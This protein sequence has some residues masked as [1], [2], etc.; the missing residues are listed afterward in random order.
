MNPAFRGIGIFGPAYRMMLENDSHAPSSVD[1]VL[2]REMVKLCSETVDF[3]YSTHTP[4]DVQ[5]EKGSRPKLD[6]YVEDIGKA[7]SEEGII[8]NIAQF[9]SRLQDIA[10]Q[11]LDK[12]QVGGMEEEII[13]RGS[14]W[15]TDLARVGCV[16]CQVAGFPSRLIS[17]V[18]AKKA[19]S[20]H[21]IIEVYRARVWG[22]VDPTTNVIYRHRNGKPA[23]TWQLMND[24]KLVDQ[25]FRDESTPYTNPNQF[26]EAAITNYFVWRW[27]EHD[28][29]MS[30]VNDYY[31]SILA[32]DNSGT[33]FSPPTRW[34][35]IIQLNRASMSFQEILRTSTTLS[36]SSN[37]FI[38]CFTTK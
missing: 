8:E 3:L 11:D 31:R 38:F 33:A 7:S 14:D 12:V 25:H 34:A 22:A 28:Y 26:R 16:L 32:S 5:Y 37:I 23:T 24:T 27:K 1:N 2:L 13:E 19:Y 17:L 30:C 10:E 18:D 4:V 29:T 15:C 20:G 21:V 35:P 9:T 36:N 6:L